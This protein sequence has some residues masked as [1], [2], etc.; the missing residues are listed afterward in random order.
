MEYAL[1][2]ADREEKGRALQRCYAQGLMK[3]T[4]NP[5]GKVIDRSAVEGADSK[6]TCDNNNSGK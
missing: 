1:E 4:P 6:L 2:H 3:S 5:R